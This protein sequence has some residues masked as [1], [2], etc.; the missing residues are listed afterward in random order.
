MCP[1]TVVFINKLLHNKQLYICPATVGFIN[2]LPHNKQQYMYVPC[3]SSFH[4]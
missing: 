4:K 3:Y 2:K 1:A